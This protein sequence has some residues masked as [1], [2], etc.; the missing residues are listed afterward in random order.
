MEGIWEA[1][2]VVRSKDGIGLTACMVL[3]AARRIRAILIGLMTSFASLLPA[4]RMSSVRRRPPPSDVFRPPRLPLDPFSPWEQ[5]ADPDLPWP[6]HALAARTAAAALIQRVILVLGPPSLAALE[7]LLLS[8]TNAHSLVLVLTADPARLPLPDA[9]TATYTPALRIL[10]LSTPFPPVTDSAFA[11]A[12]VRALEA[13]ASVSRSWRAHPVRDARQLAQDSDGAF[14]VP[15]ELPA[16]HADPP[17]LSALHQNEHAHPSRP[18]SARSLSSSLSSLASTASA[19]AGPSRMSSLF[20]TVESAPASPT[21]ATFKFSTKKTPKTKKPAPPPP[22]STRAFDALVHFLPAPQLLPERVALKLVVLVTTLGGAFLVGEEG[23]SVRGGTDTRRNSALYPP[24]PPSATL[25]KRRTSG[26]YSPPASPTLPVS[27]PP[28]FFLAA[29][30]EEHHPKPSRLSFLSFGR[31]T[32]AVLSASASDISSVAQYGSKSAPLT[33]AA[34]RSASGPTRRHAAHAH[35][36]HVVPNAYLAR[37][38]SNSN[39]TAQ[40][41][42]R[43]GG[44][45]GGRR[46]VYGASSSSSSSA[47]SSPLASASSSPVSSS[48]LASASSSPASTLRLAG[49]VHPDASSSSSSSSTLCAAPAPRRALHASA[50]LTRP[51]SG[52]GAAPAGGGTRLTA[53]LAAFVGAWGAPAVSAPVHGA[54]YSAHRAS[55]I[56]GMST[57]GGKNKSVS[58]WG[59]LTHDAEVD[60]EDG[61]GGGEEGGAQGWVVRGGALEGEHVQALEG[62]GGT[63]ESAGGGALEALL[64]GALERGRR[65]RGAWVWGVEDSTASSTASSSVGAGAPITITTIKTTT[66]KL[67][68]QRRT[69]VGPAS[70]AGPAA[71]ITTPTTTPTKPEPQRKTSVGP[72]SSNSSSAGSAV[73]MPMPMTTPKLEPQRPGKSALGDG[74]E[75]GSKFNPFERATSPL[76]AGGLPTPPES[77]RGSGSGSGEGESGEGA[78]GDET[79][80]NPSQQLHQQRNEIPKG[81]TDVPLPVTTGNTHLSVN[82]PGGDAPRRR[83]VSLPSGT[84]AVAATGLPPGAAAPYTPGKGTVPAPA[85][86]GTFR[87][88]RLFGGAGVVG[89]KINISA[90]G[91]NSKISAGGE[92]KNESKPRRKRWWAIWA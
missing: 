88:S 55:T 59:A 91:E 60:D 18:P 25:H 29:A 7:S 56:S 52:A 33:P 26:T 23:P 66:T 58:E 39:S 3:S 47:S 27:R 64:V 73:P 57:V 69:S 79:S 78:C 24:R 17:F 86:K 16:R 19:P 74:G 61:W 76:G 53:A 43:G 41:G 48:P 30:Q 82:A 62:V 36:V 89:S 14:T 11:I 71:P 50:P 5:P 28:S 42:G 10:S 15:E 20:N 77:V 22:S 45:G 44:G 12:L 70:S 32:S 38:H 51:T 65:R 21:N 80:T 67:E 31:R 9:A 68:P 81:G 35:M 83:S 84:G 40:M 2:V 85:P 13:A 37:A 4:S 49:H 34:G 54:G 87:R 72:A 8:P 90:D 63:G 92:N 46:A 75:P 6:V 1:S